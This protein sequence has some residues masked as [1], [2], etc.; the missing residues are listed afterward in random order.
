[1]WQYLAQVLLSEF[2]APLFP[3][4]HLHCPQLCFFQHQRSPSPSAATSFLPTSTLSLL[5]VL[6][7][8]FVFLLW[9]CLLFFFLILFLSSQ[10]THLL[11]LLFL[12]LFL[13]SQTPKPDQTRP[14]SNAIGWL[15]VLS[16][17]V[18]FDGQ[19]IKT[20]ILGSMQKLPSTPTGLN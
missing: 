17:H 15:N 16:S 11:L 3:L 12:F 1:M 10:T 2:H 7:L 13:T 5:Q 14:K 20:E 18:S 9:V 4:H 6:L 8:W 19:Y